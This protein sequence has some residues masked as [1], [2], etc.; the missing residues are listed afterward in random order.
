MSGNP[1]IIKQNKSIKQ[2][3]VKVIKR[4]IM[5]YYIILSVLLNIASFGIIFK[6]ISKS[7]EREDE[8]KKVEDDL[9]I[10]IANLKKDL[11]NLDE[12]LTKCVEYF[13]NEETNLNTDLKGMTEIEKGP[14]PPPR[15]VV[16]KN[17]IRELVVLYENGDMG[18]DPSIEAILKQCNE[19]AT[20]AKGEEFSNILSSYT[21]IEHTNLSEVPKDEQQFL[22]YKE[23]NWSDA[24][25]FI[26]VADTNGNNR[27]H[28]NGIKN[29]THLG[30][31]FKKIQGRLFLI[32]PTAQY[33]LEDKQDWK[34]QLDAKDHPFLEQIGHILYKGKFLDKKYF[35][36][37][38]LL[39]TKPYRL[40]N[41]KK[42]HDDEIT[43]DV[44]PRTV[45]AL[46]NFF[47]EYAIKIE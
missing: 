31:F 40:I 13:S 42:A 38:T 35:D 39:L 5:Y 37:K 29:N 1:N 3:T 9:T 19:K 34:K 15:P 7:K 18:V 17:C 11:A 16:P 30:M 23:D 47:V 26:Y 28:V 43:I 8:Y 4:I 21:K 22:K 6:M 12:R 41:G 24:T 36:P 45:K 2:Q 25:I 46:T 14:V 32:V 44:N 20:R 27:A 10:V 33:N